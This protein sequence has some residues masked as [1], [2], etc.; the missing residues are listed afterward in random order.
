MGKFIAN[1]LIATSI[2]LA[3]SL[4]V[5]A[6]A[7]AGEPI[8]AGINNNGADI[9]QLINARPEIVARIQTLIQQNP[10]L[11]ASIVPK[12][13]LIKDIQEHPQLAESMINANPQLVRALMNDPQSRAILMQ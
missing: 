9:Q 12:S 4:N 13:A 5:R 7:P 8:F 2:V 10:T 1:G 6:E 3:T 11:V